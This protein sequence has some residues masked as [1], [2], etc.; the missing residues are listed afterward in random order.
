MVGG[1]S[2]TRSPDWE[3]SD[4]APQSS[5]FQKVWSKLKSQKAKLI[6]TDFLRSEG[7]LSQGQA[8]VNIALFPSSARAL[9][10]G[11]SEA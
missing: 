9:A 2:Q 10:V 11:A 4:S 1:V 7:V 3:Q 5:V 6:E 8:A